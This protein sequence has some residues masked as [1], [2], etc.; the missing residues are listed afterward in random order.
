MHEFGIAQNIVDL[1]TGESARLGR[2]NHITKVGVKIGDVSGVDVE[3]LR[4]SFDMIVSDC[5]L[6]PLELQVER[7]PHRRACQKCKTTFEVDV[8]RFDASCPRCGT[9]RTE[10][11]SGA[12]LE[13][14]Y[15]E[16][17]DD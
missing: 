10:F 13:I 17:E 14:A 16:V 11:V 9:M 8:H 7:V 4:F 2:G 1:V 5:G 15:V 12:E 3:S 6:A